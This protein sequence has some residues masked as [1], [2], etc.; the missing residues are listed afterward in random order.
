MTRS[1]VLALTLS[2]AL[3]APLAAPLAAQGNDPDRK[4]A[5][6]TLPAG[7]QIR[8]DRASANAADA[9]V[10]STG[11][12]LHFT[13][14][15]SAVYYDPSRTASGS[16]AVKA[17]FT[18]TKAPSHPEAYGLLFAGRN[19]DAPTQ[20]YFYFIV[21]GD[22]KFSVKH[23][24]NDTEVHTIQD[25]TAHQA[26]RPQDASGRATN[27][28]E[29]TVGAQGVSYRVNGTEVFSQRLADVAGSAGL[30]ALAGLAG[31]RVNHNLDVQVDGFAVT[32]SAIAR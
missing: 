27:A 17:T 1:L 18:Q 21:R 4:V 25:W 16:Y 13:T 19:L 3:A 23:R 22:G 31:I 12:A 24:A 10:V 7:W 28:L 29:V 15:P 5:G 6:G 26:I 32:Q 8:L 14:G 20:E 2:A 30:Q 11:T 9:K